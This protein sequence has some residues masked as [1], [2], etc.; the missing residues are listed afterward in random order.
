MDPK[1]S[2]NGPGNDSMSLLIDA[3]A[4]MASPLK[5]GGSSQVPDSVVT[6]VPSVLSSPVILAS[7]LQRLSDNIAKVKEE[8]FFT[9]EEL[10]GLDDEQWKTLGDAIAISLFDKRGVYE[11]HG[12]KGPTSCHDAKKFRYFCPNSKSL[13]KT[14]GIRTVFFIFIT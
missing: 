10:S 8:N 4:N 7:C 1:E 11:F 14:K 2:S 6:S 12:S 13:K 9:E 3:V 5:S